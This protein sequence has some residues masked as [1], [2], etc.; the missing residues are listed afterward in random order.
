MSVDF[1]YRTL[2]WSDPNEK[3]K[4]KNKREK[5]QDTKVMKHERQMFR[6]D[7]VMMWNLAQSTELYHTIQLRFLPQLMKNW[8]KSRIA[9]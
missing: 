5:K 3:K 4:K 6:I 7:W 1:F 2:I 9:Y 8:I